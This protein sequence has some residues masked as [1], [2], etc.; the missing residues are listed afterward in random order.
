EH[1]VGDA[2]GLRRITHLGERLLAREETI[3]L[4]FWPLHFGAAGRGLEQTRVLACPRR[5][6]A[7]LVG[8]AGEDDRADRRL[9]LFERE[10]RGMAAGGAKISLRPGG[11]DRCESPRLFEELR[12]LLEARHGELDASQLHCKASLSDRFCSSS[13]AMFR[14]T[15]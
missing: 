13:S 3:H 5:N 2:Q 14:A 6:R 12:R 9:A 1:H 4:P 8:V 15:P 7:D 11:S 10:D